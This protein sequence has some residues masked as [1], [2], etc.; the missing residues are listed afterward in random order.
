MRSYT[1]SAGKQF[2]V[3]H[4]LFM[5]ASTEIGVRFSEDLYFLN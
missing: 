3:F 4:P 1:V 5:L 2:F